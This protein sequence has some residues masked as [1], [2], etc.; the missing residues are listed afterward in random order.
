MKIT[1][2]LLFCLTCASFSQQKQ[3]KLYTGFRVGGSIG[4]VF[5]TGDDYRVFYD[6]DTASWWD[7]GSFDGAGFVS[8]QINDRFAIHTEIMATRFGYFGQI[9]KNNDEIDK[10]LIT[11]RALMIP[12]LAKY[13][14]RQFNQSIQF[15]IGPHFTVNFG[16]WQEHTYFTGNNK[17][18]TS[19][20]YFDDESL[21]YPPLGI[22]I[23]A[24]FGYITTK[25]GTIFADVRISEDLGM[26]KQKYENEDGW[27]PILLRGKLSFSLGWEI[28]FSKKTQEENL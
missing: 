10:Y 3:K 24:N 25:A 14:R 7:G 18:Q 20:Y 21:K 19:W 8:F 1:I 5:P 12:I 11:R 28:G 2:V 6:N 13:T 9:Y 15:F 17:P 22:T 4:M 26:I 23:G 16:E 27:Y